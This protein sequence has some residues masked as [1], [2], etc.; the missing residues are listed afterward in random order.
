MGAPSPVKTPK[1]RGR[2]T[3]YRKD[4]V[5][6]EWKKTC[7]EPSAKS[8]RKVPKLNSSFGSPPA[9]P[10]MALVTAQ[11]SNPVTPISMKEP[12]DQIATQ[13]NEKKIESA[14]SPSFD[15]PDIPLNLPP[16][17]FFKS[18]AAQKEDVGTPATVSPPPNPENE[19]T[20]FRKW[21]DDKLSP[22]KGVNSS[23]NSS[24]DEPTLNGVERED[25]RTSKHVASDESSADEAEASPDKND[26]FPSDKSEEKEARK[27][28]KRLKREEKEKRRE[29]RRKKKL[30]KSQENLVYN[31][32]EDE[33]SCVV[34]I[35][36]KPIK[37]KIKP[38]TKPEENSDKSS[39][40]AIVTSEQA[41]SGGDR[42]VTNMHP[43][44][45]LAHILEHSDTLATVANNFPVV[46]SSLVHSTLPFL[47]PLASA[48]N[49]NN[50]KLEHGNVLVT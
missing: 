26:S 14:V 44:K 50:K 18:K 22:I 47:Q 45:K 46:N 29:E 28:R 36:P 8:R 4:P 27:E 23:N 35:A 39:D 3:G 30:L 7:D 10:P 17:K 32:E 42:A 21:L 31:I 41:D 2:P 48:D 37:L 43:K 6:G 15:P 9:I 20:N 5:T 24:A 40:F 34:R 16:K 11:A 38:I 19:R 49:L 33:D 1:K 13:P 25:L 12:E